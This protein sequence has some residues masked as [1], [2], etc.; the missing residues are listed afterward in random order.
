MQM[1]KKIDL[2]LLKKTMMKMSNFEY[3]LGKREVQNKTLLKSS[4][5]SDSFVKD[6]TTQMNLKTNQTMSNL[7][8]SFVKT[9]I[10]FFLII[11]ISYFY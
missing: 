1:L 2:Y 7:K 11:Y 4:K 10:L 5:T 6:L 9:S 3:C 8:I